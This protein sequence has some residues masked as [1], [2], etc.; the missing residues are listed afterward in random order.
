[1]LFLL[2][3]PLYSLFDYF[4][5]TNRFPVSSII[6]LLSS[7]LANETFFGLLVSYLGFFGYHKSIDYFHKLFY[8]FLNLFIG[9]FG[10]I[11]AN[12]EHP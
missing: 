9:I 3:K 2:L 12:T 10:I 4:C 6:S 5:L 1:M 11:L 8:R 7:G